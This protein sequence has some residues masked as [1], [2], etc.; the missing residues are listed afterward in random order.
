[1]P[2]HFT[3]MSRRSTPCTY[4]RFRRLPIQVHSRRH[5]Y[6]LALL[7][8][9]RYEV[10]QKPLR[11]KKTDLLTSPVYCATQ[12]R[13]WCSTRTHLRTHGQ[14][15]HTSNTQTRAHCGLAAASVATLLMYPHRLQVGSEARW[16]GCRACP[17]LY[18][19]AYSHVSCGHHG[20]SAPW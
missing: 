4:S 8:T 13:R 19:Q 20:V 5:V 17:L 6:T 2:S 16:L 14:A 1:V 10:R 15:V 3:H 18:N 9:S 12:A 11:G 7:N